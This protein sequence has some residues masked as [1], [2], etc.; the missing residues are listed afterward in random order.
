M[1]ASNIC[2]QIQIILPGFMLHAAV[3]AIQ[4]KRIHNGVGRDNFCRRRIVAKRHAI[5]TMPRVI[6]ES[7]VAPRAVRMPRI[8]VHTLILAILNIRRRWVE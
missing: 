6:A 4:T 1:Y 2:I 3:T 5:S 8:I 7:F